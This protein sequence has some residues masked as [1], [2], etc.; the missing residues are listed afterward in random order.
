MDA[1]SRDVTDDVLPTRLTPNKRLLFLISFRHAQ[2]PYPK[3]PHPRMWWMDLRG[4]IKICHLQLFRTI[5]GVL[6][7][8][9]LI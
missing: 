4:V 9:L 8:L 6:V 3:S 5:D 2:M 1:F 7:D